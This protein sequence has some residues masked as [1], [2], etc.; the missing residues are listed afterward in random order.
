V[1]QRPTRLPV[2]VLSAIC[3]VAALVA[4]ACGPASAPSATGTTRST[5]PC[6]SLNPAIDDAWRG[7][8]IWDFRPPYPDDQGYC[9]ARDGS[10]VELI[11]TADDGRRAADLSRQFALAARAGNAVAMVDGEAVLESQF[12]N[13]PQRRIENDGSG[14]TVV[15]PATVPP[16]YYGAFLLA[17]RGTRYVRL[18]VLSHD[19]ESISPSSFDV[20]GAVGVAEAL[21]GADWHFPGCDST[22]CLGPPS[23]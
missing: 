6:T 2:I 21:L 23:R 8:T 12:G 3:L 11:A 19:N 5:T 4:S 18:S 17:R 13:R 14:T 20:S 15:V 16:L 22:A 1:R 10:G 9:V 7:H